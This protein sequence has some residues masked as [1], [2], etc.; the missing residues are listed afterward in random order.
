M[1]TDDGEEEQL[2]QAAVLQLVVQ[3]VGAQTNIGLLKRY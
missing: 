2:E 1:S 3:E